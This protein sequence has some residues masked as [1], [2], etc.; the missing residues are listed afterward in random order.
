[1]KGTVG[2]VRRVG[3]IGAGGIVQKT[4]AVGYRALEGRVAVTAL[5]DPSESNRDAAGT[6]LR[7]APEHRYTDY[8]DMLAHAP[9]DTVVI[10]TPHSFHK[11]QAIAAAEAGKAVISE[12][13]MAITL[14]EAAAIL[15]AVKR[16]GVAYTVVHNLL[17]SQAVRGAAHLLKELGRPLLGRGEMLGNKSEAT[18]TIEKDWRASKRYGGGALIDSSYHEIYTVET[19]MGSP[20]K[21]VSA[22]IATLKFPID[23]DDTA[24]MTYEHENGAASTVHAAWHTRGPAHR[25]RWVS[26][27]GTRGAIRVVYADPAPLSRYKDAPEGSNRWETVDAGELPG[28]PAAI[29][30]DGTGHA[31][32]LVAAFEALA[33]GGPM[34]ITGAQAL[35]NLA[36][37]DAA[38][39][40]SDE[41]RGIEVQA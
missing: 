8:R 34:P 5:A 36:I 29:E 18:T 23:V 41:R 16:H 33:N 11:E 12:K 25:G 24:L 1:M 31:A 37:V 38:C 32:F 9:I 20:V 35:H 22:R 21:Y 2:T 14:E 6:L 28:I 4:H 3:L 26:I 27:N 30:G 17:F 19:L 7:I 40:S 39:R 15:S 10:A 13:P